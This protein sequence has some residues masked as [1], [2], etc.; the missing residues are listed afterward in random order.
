MPSGVAEVPAADA[1]APSIVADPAVV[2]T[3]IPATARV[4]ELQKEVN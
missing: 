1:A 4:T 2:V 3:P